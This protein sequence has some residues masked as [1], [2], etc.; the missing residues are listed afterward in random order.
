MGW[1]R[2]CHAH[3]NQAGKIWKFAKECIGKGYSHR[4]FRLRFFDLRHVCDNFVRPSF[5]A[6]NKTLALWS[7][8]GATSLPNT[9]HANAPF[10]TILAVPREGGGDRKV[11]AVSRSGL[12]LPFFVLLVPFY[13]FSDFT[14]FSRIFPISSGIFQIGPFPLSRPLNLLEAPTRNSPER[15]HDT[16]S[17]SQ[18]PDLSRKK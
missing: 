6:P 7:T 14:D 9:P 2:F 5:D 12:V 13:H 11:R 8:R 3:S 1:G 17:Q 18:N 15:V 4:V 16:N 10:P